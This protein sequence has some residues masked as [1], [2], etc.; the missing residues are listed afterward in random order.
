M[1]E[2]GTTITHEI[3]PFA[4]V[5]LWLLDALVEAKAPKR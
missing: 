5:P 3:G 4:I 1:S 2:Q